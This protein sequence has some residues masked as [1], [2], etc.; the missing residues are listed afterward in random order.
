MKRFKEV[1]ILIAQAG[2]QQVGKC[3]MTGANHIKAIVRNPKGLEQFFI[4]ALT[5]GDRN[6]QRQKLSVMKRFAK[7]TELALRPGCAV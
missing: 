1:A 7:T 4:F 3:S 5:P 2:L 6:G